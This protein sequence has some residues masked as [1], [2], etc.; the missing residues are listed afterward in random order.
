LEDYYILEPII[1]D[2]AVIL[3][4]DGKVLFDETNSPDEVELQV[5]SAGSTIRIRKNKAV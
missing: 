3:E 1:T 5:T 4:V 2:N